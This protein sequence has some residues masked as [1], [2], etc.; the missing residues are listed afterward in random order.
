IGIVSVDRYK[1]F[2][3]AKNSIE[4]EISR[5][6]KLRAGKLLLLTAENETVKST[7]DSS[8]LTKAHEKIPLNPPL[9]KGEIKLPHLEKG[10]KGGFEKMLPD[11]TLSQLLQRPEMDDRAI[12]KLSPPPQPL[13]SEVK[14]R[15]E[16]EVKYEGYV[17]K[18]ILLNNR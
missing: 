8:G 9:S 14:K 3:E 5:L 11:T 17:K 16:I 1:K 15:V 10:G 18:K 6:K 4:Q 2:E 12:E 13:S 7:P